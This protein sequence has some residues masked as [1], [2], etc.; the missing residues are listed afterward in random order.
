MANER[1]WQRYLDEAEAAP[2]VVHYED[3]AGDY[4]G[5]I[6]RVLA[7]LS[8]PSAAGVVVP[9]PTLKKQAD[10]TTDE[11]VERYLTFKGRSGASRVGIAH[12]ASQRRSVVQTATPG[13]PAGA[14]AVVDGNGGRCPP[15]S[16]IPDDWKR[17]IGENKLQGASDE[18]IV[19]VLT[20]NGFDRSAAAAEVVRAADNPYLA[21]GDWYVQRLKKAY[22]LLAVYRELA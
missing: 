14:I 1:G 11:W 21:A 18:S 4:E 19:D 2:L 3:L 9:P 16:A 20:K 10:A 5:E 6:R 8:V 15:Y 12:H 22:S 17:W 13:E 7:W